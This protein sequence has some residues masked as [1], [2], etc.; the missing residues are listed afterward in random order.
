MLTDVRNGQPQN[1][2]A[3]ND[4]R[5]AP[6]GRR[7]RG[8][9][10]RRTILDAASQVI[11]DE[12]VAAL[13]HRAVARAAGVPLAR[14]S[15]HFPKV[16]DLM[17]AATTQYLHEFD[18]RLAASAETAR[19]GRRSMV[20]ACTDFLHELVTERSGE[21]LGMVEVRLA[22]HRRGRSVDGI[23]V[24]GVI[25]SFGADEARALSIVAAMFGFAV[26]AA[27]APDAVPRAQVRAYVQS[28]LGSER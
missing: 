17:V 18:A 10:S 25:R 9:A 8:D 12:G 27:S 16:E 28:I 21:F 7:Q 5:S 26:L 23:G 3:Q 15:Y 22:L 4:E 6:D 2:Q 13:T 1:D 14:V 19:A 11:V 24:V 20:E